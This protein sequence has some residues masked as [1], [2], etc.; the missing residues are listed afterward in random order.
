MT[1]RRPIRRD[2][3]AVAVCRVDRAPGAREVVERPEPRQARAQEV[4]GLDGQLRGGALAIGAERIC[5]RCTVVVRVMRFETQTATPDEPSSG[6]RT[7]ANAAT[8]DRSLP[9]RSICSIRSTPGSI[10]RVTT[11]N[12]AAPNS[13]AMR[14]VALR[15]SS[16]SAGGDSTS[17]SPRQG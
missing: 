2:E 7:I 16:S 8:G 1:A 11:W 12:S 6:S 13:P 14:R 3:A 5:T 10:G 9:A 4:D 17:T 15:V